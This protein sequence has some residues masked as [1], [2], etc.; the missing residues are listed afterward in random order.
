MDESEYRLPPEARRQLKRRKFIMAIFIVLFMSFVLAAGY[1]I[2]HGYRQ[3]PEPAPLPVSDAPVSSH[4]AEPPDLAEEEPV[5]EPLP[6]VTEDVTNEIV[7][8]VGEVIVVT[9]ER[10]DYADND[11][12]LIIPRLDLETPVLSLPDPAVAG[13]A[14]V[15]AKLADGVGLF[16]CSQMPGPENANVTIAGHRDI[17][18]KEFYYLDTVTDDDLMYLIWNGKKYTYKYYETLITGPRDWSAVEVKDFSALTLQTCTPIGV[19]SHRLFVI[20]KLV[21]IEKLQKGEDK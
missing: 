13:D 10:T 9:Q 20:G 8:P 21:E 3:I 14:A 6:K 17:K 5:P 1:M 2:W 12:V 4:I 7:Y 11:M 18:G 16:S 15:N 19:A